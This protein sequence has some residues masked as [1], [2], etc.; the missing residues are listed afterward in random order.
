MGW[1][2]TYGDET[3]TSI[4]TASQFLSAGTQIFTDRAGDTGLHFVHFNAMSEERYFHE[5]MG[6]GGALFDYDNDGDLD[7]YLVQG[8]R[9]GDDRTA[10][11]ASPSSLLDRLYRSDLVETGELRFVDVTAASG[12]VASGY[13]FGVAVGDFTNDG[14]PDLYITNFGSNQMYENKGNGS[15]TDVT[16][17]AGTDDPFWGTS[18]AFFDYDRDGWLDLFV[19]NYV[20]FSLTS[21]KPCYAPTGMLDY[22]GPLS[23]QP[24]P[25]RLFHNQGNGSFVDASATSRIAA[26][27]G[28][29]L[30]VIASDF[31][32]D[33]WPDIYVANDGRANQLW[34]NQHDGSFVEDALMSGTAFNEQ[35]TPEG[36]M[37][38]V[39]GDFDSDGDDDLFMTHIDQETN[40]LYR[41]AGGGLFE[42]DT[43][44][45]GL[46]VLSRGFTGFGTAWLDYDNDT[47]LD[48]LVVNGAVR[49]I[50]TLVQAGEPLPLHQ[51]NQLVRNLGNG[52]F[53]EVTATAGSIFDLAEVSRGAAAGDID[54]DGDT[55]V[56]ILNNSGPVRLLI[57]EMGDRAAW[58][59]LRLIDRSQKRDLYGTRVSCT[60]DDG[61]TL[62]R[63]VRAAASYC[64]SN[65]PRV[66]FGLGS[67]TSI[68]RIEARWPD[69]SREQWDGATY[70]IGSYY[71]LAQGSGHAIP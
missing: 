29:A 36:S 56:L 52:R 23:Y 35:G 32:D 46:G 13:G 33:G 20:D 65:D 44:E 27:Y 58:L 49:V 51:T 31:N 3:G 6:S 30:G 37:G 12:I 61:R 66:L 59:G 38:V 47:W 19:A 69:G 18:A 42:D 70:P 28:G 57:N 68:R 7:V 15:F 53:Q 62:W 67:S 54:N 1:E 5:I 43:F 40:T 10:R 71:T 26:D 63:T 34:L 2:A 8:A 50:E 4:G 14:F 9:G 24:S 48:L 41:N 22:C 25:N 17:T 60:L 55:D 21:H 16:R 39:A 64:S 11:E 45:A